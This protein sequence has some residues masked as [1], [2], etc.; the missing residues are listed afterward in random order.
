MQI[1]D[2]RD[3]EK[4][5]ED[6]RERRD[7]PDLNDPLDEEEEC[8]LEAIEALADM[9]IPDWAYG[10]QLIHEDSFEDYARDYAESIGA[11]EEDGRWPTYHIDWEAAAN[12][13][14]QDF[15]EVEFDGST[16]YVH[17]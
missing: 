8:R 10:A 3:L 16:Y 11:I 15:T 7:D 13:L 6:L 5:A 17:A 14:K 12:D 1:L 4:E 2:S 9:G